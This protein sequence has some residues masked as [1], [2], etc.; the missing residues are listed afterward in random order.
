MFARQKG[1]RVE[2]K[3]SFSADFIDI[4]IQSLNS[5]KGHIRYYTK[6]LIPLSL[7]I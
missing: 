5:L 3:Y 4:S 6:T 2:K 7:L 1:L